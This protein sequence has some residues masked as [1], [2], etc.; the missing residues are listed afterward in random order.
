[1]QLV[2]THVLLCQKLTE[3]LGLEEVK[4]RLK[5]MKKFTLET[6]KAFGL[7]EIGK[8]REVA[9]L[10]MLEYYLELASRHKTPKQLLDNLL[11]HYVWEE[12]RQVVLVRQA[13]QLST[14]YGYE[15][16]GQKPLFDP[17]L[18]VDRVAFSLL[19]A[20]NSSGGIC[21]L[22][23]DARK[24]QLR[25]MCF[26][27][28]RPMFFV[29]AG[30]QDNFG[31]ALVG[32]VITNT[33]IYVS[34]DDI[35]EG[36][37]PLLRT[38]LMQL[39]VAMRFKQS[40]LEFLGQEIPLGNHTKV[41]LA[42]TTLLAPSA[43]PVVEATFK[44]FRAASISPLPLN[45][46]LKLGLL[47]RGV[48][49][50]GLSIFLLIVVDRFMQFEE[51]LGPQCIVVKMLNSIRLSISTSKLG[52]MQKFFNQGLDAEVMRV[53][54]NIGQLVLD[55]DVYDIIKRHA[56]MTSEFKAYF[57]DIRNPS[58][59]AAA[60]SQAMVENCIRIQT[61]VSNFAMTCAVYP[62]M[63]NTVRRALRATATFLASQTGCVVY[64]ICALTQLHVND[65]LQKI[66]RLAKGATGILHI[67]GRIDVRTIHLLRNIAHEYPTLKI[68]FSCNDKSLL[69]EI[70]T[71]MNCVKLKDDE[72]YNLL[73]AMG[74]CLSE[75]LFGVV[76]KHFKLVFP[77]LKQA[78]EDLQALQK[79][80]T[81]CSSMPGCQVIANERSL[82]ITVGTALSKK[83]EATDSIS[84]LLSTP[85]LLI[86]RVRESIDEARGLFEGKLEPL[87]IDQSALE[88][89]VKLSP[90]WPSIF[91][92]TQSL[93]STV[94]TLHFFL[95]KHISILLLGERGCGKSV[96]FSKVVSYLSK[97][98]ISVRYLLLGDSP[99]YEYEVDVLRKLTSYKSNV[100]AIENFN[101]ANEY[102]V[103]MA[104]SL[105]TRR[106][107]FDERSMQYQALPNLTLLIESNCAVDQVPHSLAYNMVVARVSKDSKSNLDVLNEAIAAAAVQGH[108]SE[109]LS[110]SWQ[111]V[112]HI[113]WSW[114][115]QA[116]QM[117][118]PVLPVSDHALYRALSGILAFV[119]EDIESEDDL[120]KFIHSELWAEYSLFAS[121]EAVQ[122]ELS[123]FAPLA[124]LFKDKDEEEIMFLYQLSPEADH[125]ASLPCSVQ[126][127]TVPDAVKRLM[128]SYAQLRGKQYNDRLV[129]SP[130]FTRQIVALVRAFCRHGTNVVVGPRGCGKTSAVTC[131]AHMLE[132]ELV[133]CP[134]EDSDA[135]LQVLKEA[136]CHASNEN[137]RMLLVQM[138]SGL[139]G[140]SPVLD[141]INKI[142]H[143]YDIPGAFAA[144][145]KM[146]QLF[147]DEA[148]RK[149][150]LLDPKVMVEAVNE[151]SVRVKEH[152]H[153]VV[154]M[155]PE[156]FEATYEYYS[157]LFNKSG[158][159]RMA[160]W[161][162]ETLVAIAEERFTG[163][164]K[165]LAL[166]IRNVSKTCAIIHLQMLN[167][168]TRQVTST[169]F[170]DMV[171]ILPQ[172]Y[173]PLQRKLLQVKQNLQTGIDQVLKANTHITKLTNEISEKEPEVLRLNSEIEQLNKRLSQERINLERASKAFRKKEAAARKKSEETQ[174][175]AADA[176]RNLEHALPSLDAAMTA[177]SAIDKAE[178]N[179]LR[180]MKNPP[181][182][183]Q[184]VLEAVCILLGLK[185]D[186][187]AA[188]SVT[189]DSG[190]F[191]QKLLEFDKD[192]IAEQTSKRVR[193]Y[194][195]NPK[196]IPDEV[197]KVSRLCSSLC[198]WVRA[199]DLYAKIFKSIEPK[200]IRLLQAESE[201]AEA[202]AALR[203]ETDRVAHIESTI[204]SIQSNQQ[205]RIKRK[206][207]L[208]ASIKQTAA[209][210]ERAQLLSYSLEEESQRWKSS[211]IE[212][213]KSLQML[214]GNSVVAAMT[215]AYS[216]AMRP[217]ER[218]L[219]VEKWR[220]ICDSCKLETTVVPANDFLAPI[221]TPLKHWIGKFEYYCQNYL[222]LRMSNK[223]PLLQD[224][225]G[226]ALEALKAQNDNLTV[227][228]MNED[229]LPDI[230]RQAISKGH[231]V[232]VLNYD[233][234][235]VRPGLQAVFHRH[236]T[237]RIHAFVGLM[238][239]PIMRRDNR[240]ILDGQEVVCNPKFRLLLH[241]CRVSGKTTMLHN[242]KNVYNVVYFEYSA[243]A[244][245]LQLLKKAMVKIDPPFS[246][247]YEERVANI[248]QLEQAVIERKDNVLDI[249]LKTEGDVLDDKSVI[250]SL[251]DAKA[252]V[253]EI[254]NDLNQER[255]ELAAIDHDLPRYKFISQRMRSLIGLLNLLFPACNSS[256]L[257]VVSFL[258]LIMDIEH[259]EGLIDAF[260]PLFVDKVAQVLLPALASAKRFVLQM[261][262]NCILYVKTTKPLSES[263][264]IL[265]KRLLESR[266]STTKWSLPASAVEA[267]LTEYLN[268][269]NDIDP[270]ERNVVAEQM[271]ALLAN[272]A[273]HFGRVLQVEQGLIEQ[274]RNMSSS[275]PMLIYPDD[276]GAL[277]AVEIICE[278]ARAAGG[279]RTNCPKYVSADL[280]TSAEVASLITNGKK[281]ARW[282]IID[283]LSRLTCEIVE[284]IPA[285]VDATHRLFIVASESISFDATINNK[286][287]FASL[288]H[289]P[290][291]AVRKALY[292]SLLRLR[293]AVGSKGTTFLDGVM[294]L[295]EYLAECYPFCDQYRYL[296]TLVKR[297]QQ[298]GPSVTADVLEMIIDD[299]YGLDDSSDH[300]QLLRSI[301]RE[302]ASLP[303]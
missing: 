190:A 216:G 98:G 134:L 65:T 208:E 41:L 197:A 55:E 119:P 66:L 86:E 146:K 63:S 162:E 147:D 167:E 74:P 120:L 57:E 173:K 92:P 174:D 77:V 302:I 79:E 280:M 224:P 237:E 139:S 166:P 255:K 150:A 83:V 18:A 213:D 168:S 261:G 50:K 245:E 80:R 284:A 239:I 61:S 247:N 105:V 187:N 241:T 192:N 14:P 106:V 235:K 163:L 151:L 286:V 181:E 34:V 149:E 254:L 131:V 244:L 175:L 39:E 253:F 301:L 265:S 204:T 21:V 194:I 256:P 62:C 220:K 231:E 155:T 289:A 2:A 161:P 225:H 91:V 9:K 152:L 202:M 60:T 129:F 35:E 252:K 103:H 160:A 185:A 153:L 206:A 303:Q 198:M 94:Q 232:L 292:S 127:K 69:N 165:D 135:L 122:E 272:Q 154:T 138:P 143:Y 31:E 219:V 29:S 233:P 45:I 170:L 287:V 37:R 205:E 32:A 99:N 136:Y 38:L 157:N 184:Q 102:H 87:Q 42:R 177:V 297:W 266:P 201:L 82:A 28:G 203:E 114:H 270:L 295:H 97:A 89:H 142:F 15:Y 182:L 195:D 70:D 193:R 240:V 172:L 12:Q 72:M 93:A 47:Q 281:E 243:E 107:Y 13:D 234:D 294:K 76:D 188:K 228:G 141:L 67:S 56:K 274:I 133:V 257:P 109:A 164:E 229:R 46:K 49:E 137:H 3:D 71:R 104:S 20:V 288:S 279:G 191:L 116:K 275:Q 214:V 296:I 222:S 17:S 259:E 85:E 148:E 58:M 78:L 26:I 169:Q 158:L 11:V 117:S 209:R 7:N 236:M 211:L 95:E 126:L 268:P 210:L 52:I 54:M 53:K 96:S 88:P 263:F 113:L 123:R 186:W 36:N 290:L 246:A 262:C 115:E 100:V 43:L 223:W 183:A 260:L 189:A 8:R 40:F 108:L 59:V 64:D 196:F 51:E 251:K 73:T 271:Q 291:A 283:N 273:Q 24:S 5:E 179:E 180:S 278:L 178:L 112:G 200:R 33:W 22:R 48:S 19:T 4:E 111:R 215:V 68:L 212:V 221:M 285:N 218:R 300:H 171:K 90:G 118:N 132:M 226:L 101:P 207:N 264:E 1:M 269:V 110:S 130:H 156:A 276:S 242:V 75:R 27:F 293:I 176:H 227:V 250:V 128:Q 124:D 159:V 30:I 144:T 258:K 267:A 145:D 298:Q 84:S 249:L 299:A 25:S 248:R 277:D 23:Q 238:G 230:L 44:R 6:I 199:I 81:D 125:Q 121:R 217:N 10:L 16:N 282:L 140:Q